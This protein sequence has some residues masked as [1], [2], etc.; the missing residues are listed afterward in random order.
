MIKNR[1]QPTLTH[2]SLPTFYSK[3]FEARPLSLY[4]VLPLI[5][6]IPQVIQVRARQHHVALL[7]SARYFHSS[8]IAHHLL[9]SYLRPAIS[10]FLR[11]VLQTQFPP[12]TIFLLEALESRQ[13]T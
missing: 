13:W 11:C 4:L 2:L 8:A 3:A 6:T 7:C 12:E 1:L 10:K 9:P 5:S